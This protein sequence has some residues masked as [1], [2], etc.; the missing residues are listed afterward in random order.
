M[1]NILVVDDRAI[2]HEFL[3]MLLGYVDHRVFEATDGGA[4]LETARQL[5]IDLII[6]DIVMPKMD[7]VDFARSLIKAHPRRDRDPFSKTNTHA[8]FLYA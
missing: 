4:G 6:S 7:G 5:R 3:A 2:N 8:L 1:A